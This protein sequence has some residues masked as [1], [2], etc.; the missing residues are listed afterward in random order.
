MIGL[1]MRRGCIAALLAVVWGA[2][3]A[4]AQAVSLHGGARM[5]EEG[6]EVMVALRTEFPLHE[7]FLVELAGSVANPREGQP[8]P[9]SS[10]I[11]AQLQLFVPLGDV[12][13]PYLGAGAAAARM[14]D[15]AGEDDGVRAMASVGAGF[16]FEVAERL[17]VVLDARLRTSLQAEAEDTHSDVTVGLRYLLRRPDRPR[18]FGAP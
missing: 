5:Y 13:T 8:H 1:G 15:A 9:A 11:E 18:F 7:A 17:A 16:R 14:H 2:A 10:V 12:V 6:S 3:D 4:G